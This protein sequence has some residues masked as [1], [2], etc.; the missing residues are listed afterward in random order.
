M[1]LLA[2]AVLFTVLACV[3]EAGEHKYALN[4]ENTKIV[5]T[6]A[7]PGGKHEGGFKKIAGAAVL[8]EG[9]GLKI[10]VD[11]DCESLYSDNE[12]LT[13]H[14]KSVDFFAVKEHPTAKFVSTKIEKADKGFVVT[15]DLTLLGKT[16]QVSFPATIATGESLVLNASLT[17]NRNDFGMSFGK[18]KISDDVALQISVNAKK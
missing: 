12:K 6:G 10:N 9:A 17:I 7:K 18:G 11:I 8:A 15:G 2:S 3:V 5:W 4:A 14:L 1:R 13:G 16:K